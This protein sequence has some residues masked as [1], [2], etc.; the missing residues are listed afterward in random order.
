MGQLEDW[1]EIPYP[2]PKLDLVAVPHAVL[3]MEN[4]GLI[5]FDETLFRDQATWWPGDAALAS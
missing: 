5:T 2:Y 3:A 1:F 4:P